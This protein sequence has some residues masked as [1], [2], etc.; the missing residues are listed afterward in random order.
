MATTDPADCGHYLC[1]DMKSFYASVECVDRGLDPMQAD[2]VVA[3]PT[4]GDGTLCLAVSPHL[5]AQ[6]VS[7]RAR[8]YEI[9][10]RL[11]YIKAM[12]RMSRY[13]EASAEVFDV[14]LRWVSSED[15]HAY[16]CDEAFLDVGPYLH[17]YGVGAAE[18]ARRILN[19]IYRRTGLVATAGVGTNLFLCKVACDLVAKHAPDFIGELDGATWRERLA[20]H[21]PITDIWGV[22][23]GTARRLREHFGIRDM[24]GVARSDYEELHRVFG[25]GARHLADHAN[26]I[27]KTTIAQIKAY[28][29]QSNSISNGQVLMRDYD[30]EEARVVALEMLDESALE[31]VSRNLLAR[32]VSAWVA[33]SHTSPGAGS[34]A[35][36]SVTLSEPTD[37]R[38]ILSHTVD[39]ILAQRLGWGMKVRRVGIGLGG[40]CPA[41]GSQL[42]LFYSEEQRMQD[43]RLQEA[44]LESRR[45]FGRCAV[46]HGRSLTDAGT[47]FERNMQIGGHHA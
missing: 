6:G 12:P 1:I 15:V 5:K 10:E 37:S 40:L 23:P 17:Y 45:K 14:Y 8:V 47:G 9:P 19:D 7:G 18:L 31:L 39:S 42:S 28:V 38:T 16:S 4:R 36:G 35:G 3:D 11:N 22:G 33:W 46:M 25:V 34:G 20:H 2:L 43:R 21:R 32:Q 30:E 29:P 41:K 27:E 26:G 24:A 44:I 13:I